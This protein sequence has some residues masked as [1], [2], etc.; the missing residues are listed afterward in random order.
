PLTRAWE[1]L[2]GALVT[3]GA[4]AWVP[5]RRT[6]GYLAWGGA[7]L[8]AAGF[9]GARPADPAPAVALLPVAGT[10]G[11]LLAGRGGVPAR[12]TRLLA[13]GPLTRLGDLSY[14]WYLWHWPAIVLVGF[15]FP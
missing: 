5:G 14:G 11:L 8:L 2:A 7:V 6:A 10:A 13:T 12:V 3:L 9:L 15:A 4:A 1:F